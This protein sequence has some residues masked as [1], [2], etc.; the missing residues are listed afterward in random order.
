M[1]ADESEIWLFSYGSLRQP[2]VQIANFGRLLEGHADTLREYS[3]SGLKITDPEVVRIS[4]ASRHTIVR[5]SG[6][7]SDVVTGMVFRVT[8]EELAK[9]DAY[10]VSDYRR[11]AVQLSSGRKAFVYVASKT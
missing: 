10:E 7:P 2:Q 9:A 11:V 4:G 5:F 6:N 1:A 3:M 8:A